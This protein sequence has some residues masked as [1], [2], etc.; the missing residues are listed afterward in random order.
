MAALLTAQS[1]SK[2]FSDRTLFSDVSLSVEEGERLA[3]IGP[4]GAGKSTLIK[5]FAG[6]EDI[7]DGKITLRRGLRT[8]IAAQADVFPPGAT[9]LEAVIEA[10]GTGSGGAGQSG[11]H[12]DEHEIELAA[13]L[14]LE[15]LGLGDLLDAPCDSLSGGQRKRI[16]IARALACEPDLLLLDEPTNHLDVEGIEWL[17]GVLTAGRFACI[18]VTHDRAFLEQT[19]T[20]IIELSTAYPQGTFSVQGGYDEFL[21]RKGEF[22]DAQAKQERTL[23]MQV[24]D[25]L[26]WLSRGA[27]ARRTKSKS[28]IDASY[29]RM[30]DLDALRLRN[31]PEKA[32]RIDFTAT[33]RKTVKLL[34]GR[35]VGK[36]FGDRTLFHNLDILL[37]PG[38]KLGLIGPNGAGKTTLIRLL[39]GDL[40]SD[41]PTPEMLSEE[42]S[43]K[44]DLPHG[45]PPLGTL[46]RA[47]KLRVVLFSQHRTGLDP[48]MTLGKALAPFGRVDYRGSS[49]HV[50][51]WAN[52]FLF[53]KGQLN[54]LIKTL[55]GGEQARVHI[56]R[57]MLEPADV[58]ILDEP[59]N[60]LDLASLEVLEES[61]EEFPGAIVLVTHDRAMLD[62]LAT[63]VLA[64]DGAGGA[65]Y[66]ADYAQWKI[67]RGLKPGSNGS[68]T[69]ANG[70]TRARSAAAT[71]KKKKLSYKDKL[72]L[73][74]ME[75]AIEK[76]ESARAALEKEMTSAGADHRKLADLGRR[77]AAAQAKLDALYARW[78]ELEELV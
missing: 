34:A 28:R 65:A 71:K 29:A 35:G 3:L 48:E 39:T 46:V 50:A 30:D 38:E 69:G 13:R 51:T 6:L 42:D 10:L 20:R 66:Y 74:G 62:R 61:L 76:A 9:A 55:S 77:M 2:H 15:R 4:N 63:R 64:L 16:S 26:R 41:P 78:Q 27:K 56:A 58:L 11:H 70:A 67:L 57:L 21:R 25:D 36:S 45:T 75:A 23:S 14:T 32:A 22:L 59:T 8:A 1:I 44:D 5:I 60:D 49:L 7:D 73:E 33:D 40:E 43:I 17:E 24:R 47:D 37:T 72:E 31:A 68:E 53:D 12:H 18:V 52:M 19:A 54:S